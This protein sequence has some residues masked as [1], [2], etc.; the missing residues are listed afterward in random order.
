[1]KKFKDQEQEMADEEQRHRQT[2]YEVERKFIVGK[3]KYVC[4]L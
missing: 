1:M 3:D 4:E 2:L